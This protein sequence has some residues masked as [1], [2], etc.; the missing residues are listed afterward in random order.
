M[1]P[2][3]MHFAHSLPAHCPASLGY[4]LL[5]GFPVGVYSV[6]CHCS[7]MRG[8]RLYFCGFVQIS[9]G[10][11]PDRSAESLTR[12]GSSAGVRHRRG[13]RRQGLLSWQH[14]FRTGQL[15]DLRPEE[16]ARDLPHPRRS[17]VR[18]L[19][20]EPYNWVRGKR[21]DRNCALSRRGTLLY[22]NYINPTH[23]VYTWSSYNTL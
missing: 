13:Q 2:C 5:R 3:Y 12:Y 15:A 1:R 18:P 17:C 16:T 9:F 11:L 8:L 22:A 7:M 10:K 21:K 19:V 23:T 4:A 14:C 20:G 6:Y